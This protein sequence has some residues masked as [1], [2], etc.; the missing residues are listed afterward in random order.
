MDYLNLGCGRR[1]HPEWINAD[2]FPADPRVMQLD[3]TRG[4]PY[5]DDTFGVVYHSHLLEHLPRS[6]GKVFISECAR[7]LRPGGVLRVVVPD[8]EAIVGLYMSTLQAALSGMPGASDDYH[9]MML[10]L[11][12]Q[13]VRRVPGG[14]MLRYLRRDPLPNEQF[15]IRRFGQE[16][17]NLIEAAGRERTLALGRTERSLPRTNALRKSL[18][19]A[20]RLLCHPKET[21]LRVALGSD[22]SALEFGRFCWSGELHQWM[23]DR[24]SLRLL[25]EQCG[26]VNVAQRTASESGIPGWSTYSL[27]AQPDGAV[28]KPDSL[29]ME[30]TK[31]WR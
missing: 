1:F 3:I 6:S 13:A 27:D 30:G 15:I 16:A 7:V 8:L 25:F 4:I 28:H 9:W 29:F 14:E 24:F 20:K 19:A 23:Y 12:D 22:Y 10:E 31:T 2:R 5:P 18:A 11:Y 17:L 26:L 21:L